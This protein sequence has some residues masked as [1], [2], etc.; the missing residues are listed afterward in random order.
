MLGDSVTTDHI[1]P[2]GNIAKGGPAAKYLEAHGVKPMDFNQ[3][4]ARRGNHEV[5]VRGTFANIRL[6]NLMLDGVEGGFTKHLPRP[7]SR[8]RSTTPRCVRGGWRAARGHRGR[9]V[10]HRLLAR[11]GREGHAAAGRAR[12]DRE[13]LRAHPPQQP[14]GMGVLPLQFEPGQDAKSLGL[15]GSETIAITGIAGGVTPKKKLTVTAGDRTFTVIARVD[16][17]QETEYVAHGGIL[18]YVLRQRAASLKVRE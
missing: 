7:R 18:S 11:L 8:C 10:R 16:T 3:Y 1:S 14:V 2:A 4:G 9:A 15:T 5:M 6:K 12:G 17:P 13:E